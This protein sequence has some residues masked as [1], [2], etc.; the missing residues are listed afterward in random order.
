MEFKEIEQKLA[1]RLKPGRYLH[2]LGV[3]E[4]AAK[5]AERFGA[6]V[7]QAYVAGI[8]HDVMK[9]EEPS[10]QRAYIE[11][12]GERMSNLEIRIGKVYHQMSGAAYARL[13]LGITDPDIL[14]AIR[15][16][17]TAR[18]GMSL[19]EQ[20]IYLADLTS[21]ERDYPDVERMRRLSDRSLREGMREALVF[22]VSNQAQRH[23]P[24]CLDTCKAYNEYL[25]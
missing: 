5:L 22:A 25:R 14:H 3:S 6:D 16:H 24:L 10:V 18:R 21:S 11:K 20:I 17:T 13:E 19:L 15:Y 1:G 8:L 9:E 23:A 7:E 12:A 4:T 2:S